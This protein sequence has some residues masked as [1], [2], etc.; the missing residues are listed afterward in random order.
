M[1]SSLSSAASSRAG[2]Q[3]TTYTNTTRRAIVGNDLQP[4]PQRAAR[5]R[6]PYS[7]A[8]STRSA[9]LAGAAATPRRTRFM[10]LQPNRWTAL[11][12]IPTARDHLAAAAIDGRLYAVGGRIDGNYSRNLSS[13]EV[14]D[15]AT[16]RW[17]Q[18]A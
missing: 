16:N 4:S 18:R 12:Y 1:A 13:N 17:E 10:I 8:R 11:A 5:W 14:Y 2:R 9:A 15:P 3:P 6:P 7:M